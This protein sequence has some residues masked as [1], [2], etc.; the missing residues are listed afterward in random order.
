VSQH[1]DCGASIAPPIRSSTAARSSPRGTCIRKRSRR[2][3]A[4]VVL[5]ALE[6]ARYAFDL[7]RFGREASYHMWSSKLWGVLLFAGFLEV[8]VFDRVGVLAAAAI[9]WGIACDLEGL[10]ISMV[11]TEWRNDVPSIVHALRL[12]NGPLVPPL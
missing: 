2:T 9:Y 1:R 6:V 12:R 10:A 11:L 5:A 3:R 7:A 8:M 4:L